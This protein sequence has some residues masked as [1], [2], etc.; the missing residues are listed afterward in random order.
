[1]LASNPACFIVY[2]TSLIIFGDA[3]Q[4]IMSRC[5]SVSIVSGY[6]LENRAIEVRSPAE[7]KIF[8]LGRNYGELWWQQNGTIDHTART[9]VEVLY[10]M[11][12]KRVISRN[13]GIP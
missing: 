5:S 2:F 11:F 8:F 3:F 7:E 13:G 9:S 1:M 4:L 10:Q 6:G 12:P